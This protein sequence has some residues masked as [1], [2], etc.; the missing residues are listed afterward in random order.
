MT[1]IAGLTALIVAVIF[2]VQN[3]H[4]A[5]ISFLGVHLMLPLAGPCSWPPSQVPC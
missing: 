3:G 4:A 2:I 5:N 1:L